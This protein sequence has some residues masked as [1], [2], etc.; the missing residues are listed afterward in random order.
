WMSRYLERVEFSA[1]LVGL[2]LQRL[3]VN[4]A[5]E[6]AEGW[7]LVFR[8]LSA[9]PPGAESFGE[10][11]DDDYLFADGYALTDFL[12]FEASHP[13]SIL[14][15]LQAAREN[16]RQ[17]RDTLSAPLWTCLNRTYLGLRGTALVDEWTK[18]PERLYAGIV[19]GVQQFDGICQ[20]TLRRGD[21]WRFMQLGKYVERAQLVAVT[22]LA[23]C[24]SPFPSGNDGDEERWTNALRV[25]NALEAYGRT[26][27]GDVRAPDVLTLL[28]SDPAQPH[29]L[30]FAAERLRESLEALD[31][32]LSGRPR[33][34]P[35]TALDRISGLLCECVDAP[36]P[37]QQERLAEILESF[38]DFHGLLE[39]EYVYYRAHA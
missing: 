16:A 39:R 30:G 12:T 33:A 38:R 22:L 6:I 28:V 13:S 25:C 9:H 5:H 1:R 18:E 29:S 24:R 19:E 2:Q 20:G 27:G 7:S 8:C 36:M 34:A 14:A 32:P 26:H 31:P 21:Q 23:H 15:S 11:E 17:V 37:V 10:A 4:S 3:P 35:F